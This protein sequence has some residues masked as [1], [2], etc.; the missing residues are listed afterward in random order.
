HTVLGDGA[1]SPLED[2]RSCPA[3][4]GRR[5]RGRI[6]GAWVMLLTTTERKTGRMR[7]TPVAYLTNGDALFIISVAGGATHHPAWWLNLEAN[8][9]AQIQLGRR[10]L[11]VGAT[12]VT[13]EELSRLWCHYPAQHAVFD[14]MQHCV[15]RR[16]PMVVLH[17]IEGRFSSV[18]AGRPFPRA[19]R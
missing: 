7:T 6:F 17:P 10:M 8:P 12:E 13:P 16:I 19:N 11:R 4:Y 1:S 9:E 3:P 18:S 15:P 2:A 5:N 14:S